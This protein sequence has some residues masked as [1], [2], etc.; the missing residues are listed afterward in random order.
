MANL[1]NSLFLIL[2]IN[3]LKIKES[4]YIQSSSVAFSLFDDKEKI[5]LNIFLSWSIEFN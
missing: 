4:V 1:S 2:L 3:I 5:L